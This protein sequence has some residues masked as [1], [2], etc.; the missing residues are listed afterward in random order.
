M[1]PATSLETMTNAELKALCTE[2]GLATYGTKEQL[3]E[4]LQ[5]NAAADLAEPAPTVEPEVPAAV[6]PEQAPAPEPEPAPVVKAPAILTTPTVNVENLPPVNH[7]KHV[8]DTLDA[9]RGRFPG[10]IINYDPHQ[11]IFTLEGG[12][13]GRMTLGARQPQR[14]IMLTAEGYYNLARGRAKVDFGDIG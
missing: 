5:A 6:E 13:Q 10:L 8:Q 2:A 9:V 11:E 1:E 7:A 4:R 14:A 12:R 3:I